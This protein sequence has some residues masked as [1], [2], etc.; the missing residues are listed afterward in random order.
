MNFR[1]F[2][3]QQF[4]PV[5][6]LLNVENDSS[7]KILN[8]HPCL[9]ANHCL[10]QKKEEVKTRERTYLKL[11]RWNMKFDEEDSMQSV[12]D[13]VFRIEFLHRQYQY[14]W[15]GILRGFHILLT[16]QAREWYWVHVRHSRR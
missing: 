1:E 2:P 9:R 15:K 6:E 13:F 3:K 11:E 16:S 7:S 10:N 8:P 5:E 4:P 12:R 14:P